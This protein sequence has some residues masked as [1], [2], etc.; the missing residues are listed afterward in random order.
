LAVPARKIA[1]ESARMILF[2]VC[3]PFAHI[4]FQSTPLAPANSIQR[5]QKGGPGLACPVFLLFRPYRQSG[6]ILGSVLICYTSN[7][8]SPF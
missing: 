4:L 5:R 8:P 2:M 6:R 7:G 3:A 1:C